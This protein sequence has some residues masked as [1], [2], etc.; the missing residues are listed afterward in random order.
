MH[1]IRSALLG[2]VATAVMAL[3]AHQT[4][5][6]QEDNFVKDNKGCKIMNPQPRKEETVTW[7][8]E[9]KN[10][11]AS[12]KGVLQ[13]FLSGIA[14]EKYEGEMNEGYAE[15]TGTLMMLDGG[16]YEGEWKRSKQE[17]KGTFFANDGNVY[18]GEWKNGKP[19]GFGELRTPEGRVVRGQWRDGEFQ[20]E[21]KE[22]PNRT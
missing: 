12:G 17:G 21:E 18:Q 14:D 9:C 3:A 19:H 11:F 20:G 2:S 5:W 13:F 10:G 22:D 4:V 16:R 6:A 8:G 1:V 15:G 7:S